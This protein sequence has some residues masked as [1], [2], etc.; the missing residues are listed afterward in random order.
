MCVCDSISS[1]WV[2]V[3]FTRPVYLCLIN[4]H[5]VIDGICVFVKWWKLIHN[6]ILFPWRLSWLISISISC[7]TIHHCPPSHL[8]SSMDQFESFACTH[9]TPTHHSVCNSRWCAVQIR[10]LSGVVASYDDHRINREL[11]FDEHRRWN[12]FKVC[13]H[14]FKSILMQ[15]CTAWSMQM[16][17]ATLFAS[18]LLCVYLSWSTRCKLQEMKRTNKLIICANRVICN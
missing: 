18:T 7:R 15:H 12:L 13:I 9:I 1:S 16:E 3:L 14:G 8:M 5:V 17:Q 4:A 2:S 11:F 6:C 10:R